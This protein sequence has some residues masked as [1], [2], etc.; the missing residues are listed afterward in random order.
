MSPIPKAVLYY[1]P[2]SVWA[3]AANSKEKGYGADE[4]ELKV[5]NLMRGENFSPAYI[6]INPGG[7]VPALVVPLAETLALDGPKKYRA[8]TDTKSVLEFLD[9][10]RSA[11][12]TTNTTSLAPA[13]A[14]APATMALSEISNKTISLLH[15]VPI[16]FLSLAASTLEDLLAHAKSPQAEFVN[17]R[18][19]AL[20]RYMTQEGQEAS[21][22]AK[23]LWGSRHTENGFIVRVYENS[24]V[25]VSALNALGKQEREA[26]Y[27]RSVEVWNSVKDILA[28]LENML[29]GPYALGDQIS[30]ADM[31]LA[32]WFTRLLFVSGASNPPSS[33]P[34]TPKAANPYEDVYSGFKQ[35]EETVR[36]R[37]GDD[38]FVLGSKIRAF[39]TLIK[40]R[41]S[42]KQVYGDEL[43]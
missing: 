18:Q 27:K 38:T 23:R 11:A 6:R 7:T 32:A 5:V 40:N 25:P 24:S 4:L 28:R 10:S 16:N 41:E 37:T 8:L 30:L 3:S 12:S 26:F 1:N 9:Q 43:H 15:S 19:A 33:A 20:Q 39:F 21:E 31:H 22:Q 34:T 2:L 29:L 35:L 13:P 14:L 42:W 17:L 36:D